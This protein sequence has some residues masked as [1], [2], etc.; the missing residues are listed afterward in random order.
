MSLSREMNLYLCCAK[1]KMWMPPS[2][3]VGH[4]DAALGI[5]HHAVG[6][7][8]SVII[9]FARHHVEHAAPEAGLAFDFPLGADAAF[10][11]ELASARSAP[12]RGKV[13]GPRVLL[14]DPATAT[15][16]SSRRNHQD[17]KTVKKKKAEGKADSLSPVTCRFPLPCLCRPLPICPSAH[18]LSFDRPTRLSVH[19]VSWFVS[20]LRRN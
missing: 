9:G 11:Q 8:Q 3:G 16:G 18:C 12:V 6:V 13:T 20:P 14:F 2:A 1:S 7:D 10:V 19:L 5:G 17:T 15:P 4:D